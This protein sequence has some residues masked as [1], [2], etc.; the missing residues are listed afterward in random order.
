M[1]TLQQRARQVGATWRSAI[2]AHFFGQSKSRRKHIRNAQQQDQLEC[3]RSTSL[4]SS[5]AAFEGPQAA[6]AAEASACPFFSAPFRGFLRSCPALARPRDPF[7]QSR[8]GRDLSGERFPKAGA[9]KAT[10]NIQVQEVRLP[11]RPENK[12]GQGKAEVRSLHRWS[13]SP[14]SFPCMPLRTHLP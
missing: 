6:A 4:T 3:L 9:T 8:D 10:I 7:Q 2:Q 11:L 14:Q 13:G 1:W 5:A 12:G